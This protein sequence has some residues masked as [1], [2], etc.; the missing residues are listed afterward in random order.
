MKKIFSIFLALVM[1]FTCVAGVD[2]TSYAASDDD[3]YFTYIDEDGFEQSERRPE[4][5]ISAWASL[6]GTTFIK[7]EW[8]AL[9]EHSFWD[10]D[11]I[12]VS[13]YNSSTKK[14]EHIKNLSITTSSYRVCDLKKNSSHKFAIRGYVI[15]NGKKYYSE[16][17]FVSART[18][19]TATT[20]ITSVK[21][22]SAGK[23]KIK[24]KK[25]SG[26]SGY[27]IKYSTSS[28]I[29]NNASTCTLVVSGANNT[30]KTI[31]GLAKKKYYVKVCT[32]KSSDSYKY[33]SY[34]SSVKSVKI[35]KGVS[36][37]KMLNAIKTDTS[38]RKYI[39]EYTNKGVDIA[40]YKT[41][42]E[43]FKAIYN[44]HSKH[45][46]DF[47]WTCMDCNINF[48]TCIAYL[49]MNS[50]KTY[51]TYIYLAAGSVKN[52]DGSTAVHKWPVIYIA[53]TAYIFDPRLQ[54]YTGNKTGTDYFGILRSSKKGK[55]FLFDGWMFYWN[56]SKDETKYP[57]YIVQPEA[58]PSKVT[59]KKISSSKGSLTL[60]WNTV[61][62]VKG[63]EIVYSNNK[64]FADK[65]TVNVDGKNTASKTI[66]GLKP[67]KTYYVK[68]RAYKQYG[69]TKLYG[70][71]SAVK[72]IKVK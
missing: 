29:P 55:T 33:C 47:G 72:N 51:D 32:Y 13:E 48:N 43:R 19:P 6:I 42:Y 50:N 62:S 58:K 35:K 52:A 41:T 68:I 27:I 10:V 49:F 8:E 4:P 65:T 71:Y 54:G 12:Q 36:M 61:K 40:K 28:S 14:Y 31:S 46:T 53:G 15:R 26:V 20:S 45:N 22:V 56:Y 16:S 5:V 25:V 30:S 37:K 17:V 7:L 59:V 18:A 23:M 64:N 39:L 67:G 9:Y 63:Y 24:W 69:K 60:K 1:I 38:G 66:K 2:F 34:Y 57:E 70:S 11:G 3:E 21:Y 44:W